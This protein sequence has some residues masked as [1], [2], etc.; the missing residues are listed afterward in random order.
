MST[1][2]PPS[3]PRSGLCRAAYVPRGAHRTATVPRCHGAAC[4]PR[5]TPGWG[6]AN[7]PLRVGSGGTGGRE[8]NWR[9]HLDFHLPK[10]EINCTMFI[11]RDTAG[12]S[13]GLTP[14]VLSPA[15]TQKAPREE[16]TPHNLDNGSWRIEGRGAHLSGCG[17][18]VTSC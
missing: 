1:P 5:S 11:S 3:P 4:F 17:P 6:G 8:E 10:K 2:R 7:S 12:P 13:G 9:L 18:R 15:G 14:G 16:E